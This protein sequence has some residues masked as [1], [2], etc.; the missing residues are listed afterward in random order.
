MSA[1]AF[2][3]TA[4]SRALIA[5]PIAAV[6]AAAGG[7]AGYLLADEVLGHGT[8]PA[9][10]VAAPA[11]AAPVASP[12]PAPEAPPPVLNAAAATPYVPLYRDAARR[13]DVNWLL[14]ASIHRQ[15]TAFSTAEGTYHG[16]NFAGCCAGPM[17]FNVRNGDPST[18][19]RFRGA[20]K[21]AERPASYPHM[22]A[23]HPSVYDDFDSIHAAASLLAA[24]GATQA[25]DGSAWRA[26]YSYYGYDANGLDYANEVVAR[27]VTWSR[28]GFDPLAEPDPALIAEY[29]ALY[30]AF[31]RGRF[32]DQVTD[33]G[34]AKRAKHD[35]KDARGHAR[36]E[37]TRQP[38]REPRAERGTSQPERP[39]RDP[40]PAAPVKPPSKPPPSST[41]ATTPPRSATVP[42]APP[43]P[44]PGEAL[45]AP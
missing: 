28:N 34:R 31:E 30:G 35:R 18:W 13:F 27:A 45:T 7:A 8:V 3:A 11:V 26:A 36:E 19:E 33:E 39:A 24:N 14:L 42:E 5:V 37:R 20:S 22:T 38:R 10:S 17:Q 23:A 43:A 41:A 25:L 15:E 2:P 12:A 1:P 4:A 40:E 21:R 6:L 9:A 32:A 16:R 44:A 29:E